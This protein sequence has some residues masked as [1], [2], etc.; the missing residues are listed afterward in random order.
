MPLIEHPRPRVCRGSRGQPMLRPHRE[1]LDGDG[2]ERELK[3]ASACGFG[4]AHTLSKPNQ[5]E[6][7]HT[8]AGI[9]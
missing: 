2:S 9:R 4:F 5:T 7:F 8:T 3:P 6:L 1:V